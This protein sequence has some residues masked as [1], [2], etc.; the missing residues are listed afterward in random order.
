MEGNDEGTMSG[1]PLRFSRGP[2]LVGGS[3][4]AP[5]G[6]T[7]MGS[8]KH[9][10]GDP[11]DAALFGGG[12]QLLPIANRDGATGLHHRPVALSFET[13]ITGQ[14][15]SR[16]PQGDNVM[17]CLHTS[18]LQ[19]VADEVNTPGSRSF[20]TEWEMKTRGERLAWAR[21]QAGYTSKSAAARALGVAIST[22]NSHERAEQPGGRDYSPEEA[23]AYA[24]AFRVAHG[25]LI[26]GKGDPKA[27]GDAIPPQPKVIDGLIREMVVAG[28]VEAGS[29]R[30]VDE[31]FDE[32][33]PTIHAPHDPKYPNARQTYFQIEGD[34]MNRATPPLLPG[35]YVLCVDYDDLENTV[36]LRD[37][38]KV[39]IERSKFDGQ[40]REWSVKE[41]QVFEDRNEFHPR[42]DNP[43]HKPII[44]P[45]NHQPD[46]GTEVKIL[47]IV[48]GVFYPEA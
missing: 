46:D 13:E 11:L 48:R 36:P 37:G 20:A 14:L 27:G 29:F 26:T 12:Y 33:L 4:L 43:K 8:Y 6:G 39:V 24:R 40:M 17:N 3:I 30:E 32:E 15:G 41:V 16:W 1:R 28:K 7:R 47:G 42:S 21:T 38:M 9:V 5:S 25:W 34:S 10:I 22:Y 35:G 18:L 44:V 23:E 45:R 31:F 19:Y 2:V